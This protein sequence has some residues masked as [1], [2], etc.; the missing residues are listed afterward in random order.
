VATE[1]QCAACGERNPAGSTFCVFCGTYLGWD[2]PGRGPVAAPQPPQPTVSPVDIAQPPPTATGPAA[3][4]PQPASGSPTP[5]T[6]L[7]GGCPSCGQQNDSTRRFCSRCGTPLAAAAPR[8]VA[9]SQQAT[10]TRR[11]WWPFGDPAERRARR[12]YRR[13]LPLLYR[14]RRVI[15]TALVLILIPLLLTAVGRDPV[16]WAKDRWYDLRGSTDPIP[17]V[18]AKAVPPDSVP[19]PYDVL[20][21]VDNSASD[22]WATEWRSGT[23]TAGDCGGAEGVGQI[24]LV[25]KEPTRIRGLDIWT[26]VSDPGERRRQFRPRRLDVSFGKDGCVSDELTD[27]AERQRVDFDTE[28]EVGSV[29]IAIGSTFAPDVN[30]AR[31]LVAIGRIVLLRRPG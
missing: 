12:D 18:T 20:G 9:P 7:P 2:E 26:G 8:L 21:V 27:T 11:G 28:V 15:V 29:T 6:V 1:D 17:D 25:L 30:P 13:S 19:L 31:N 22:A 16:G 24:L 4:T 23:A 3:W 5:Q 14:W 10:D